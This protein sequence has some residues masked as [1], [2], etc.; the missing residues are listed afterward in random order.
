MKEYKPGKEHKYIN[1][2]FLTFFWIYGA[3]CIFIP[4]YFFIKDGTIIDD[5]LNFIFSHVILYGFFLGLILYTNHRIYGIKAR[6]DS[7]QIIYTNRRSTRVIHFKD[8]RKMKINPFG[9]KSSIK[10]Y[11]NT[12]K[13][14]IYLVFKNTY[15]FIVDIKKGLDASRNSAVYSHKKLFK[16]ARMIFNA[17]I[18]YKWGC[19]SSLIMIVGLILIFSSLSITTATDVNII[20]AISSFIVILSGFYI[21]IFIIQN[22][23]KKE[24]NKE[25]FYF[26]PRDM[27]YEKTIMKK[28]LIIFGIFI[29]VVIASIIIG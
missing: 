25:S 23:Y 16:F 28:G 15:E 22:R 1:I 26:P 10:V 18:M 20:V 8:I 29:A 5:S 27:E 3:I 4:I 11:T 24:I 21:P 14:R 13:I 19:K 2:F 12:Q 9:N 6:I 17:E 7:K